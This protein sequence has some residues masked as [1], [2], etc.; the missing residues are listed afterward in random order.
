[1]LGRQ[2][3]AAFAALASIALPLLVRADPP[4]PAAVGFLLPDGAPL[5]LVLE[6]R[7]DSATTPPG[8][9]IRTRL[10][11]PLLFHGVTVAPAGTPVWLTVTQTRPASADV[12]GEIFLR[13][14]AIR[15]ADG[16]DLPLNLPHYGL[17]APLVAANR[18]DITIPGRMA[19]SVPHGLDL[20]LPPGTVMRARTAAAVDASDPRKLVVV[21]PPPYTLSNDTPYS[22][23]TP[24]PLM[25][26]HPMA[27]PPTRRRRPTP[28]PSPTASPT[29]TASP[30][31]SPT[32]T[33]T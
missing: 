13:V 25:T 4:Q 9:Q 11:R 14:G 16:A 21:K 19:A 27:L 6:Q 26:Y 18:D 10:R 33:P 15:L 32:P 8:A 2:A 12:D 1:M 5:A 20:S 31:P 3:C 30:V 28:S 17:S 29:G 7:L 22:A 24:I 23:F